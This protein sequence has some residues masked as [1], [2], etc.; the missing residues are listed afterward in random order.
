MNVN[1]LRHQ[2]HKQEVNTPMRFM[3]CMFEI[4]ECILWK[5]YMY[6]YF[7]FSETTKKTVFESM[8]STY[9]IIKKSI[10]WVDAQAHCHAIGGHLAAFETKEEF[11]SISAHIPRGR[12]IF[13][14]NDMKVERKH[15]WEHSGEALG[16]Y[17]PW[18]GREPNNWGNEDCCS[19]SNGR[20]HDMRCSGY[21]LPF[22]CE[23]PKQ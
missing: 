12:H 4:Y 10:I 22:I 23:F 7:V 3:P 5:L 20:W 19:V 11:S 9:R 16:S 15:V 14:L 17:R 18:A 2:I 6:F 1:T 8:N 13:G 21:T